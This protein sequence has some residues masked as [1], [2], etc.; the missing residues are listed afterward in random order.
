LLSA[1]AMGSSEGPPATVCPPVVAYDQAFLDRAADELGMLPT[2]SAIEQML[3]DY[4]VTRAQLR[5]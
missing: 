5:R 1:C 2:G 3:A 4:A